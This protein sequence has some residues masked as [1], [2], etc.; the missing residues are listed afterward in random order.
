MA[1][2]SPGQRRADAQGPSHVFCCP[3]V[4]GVKR[5]RQQPPACPWIVTLVAIGGAD[6][7]KVIGNKSSRSFRSMEGLGAAA[8]LEG[9]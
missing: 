9:A 1:I 7:A 3:T 8:F 5:C 6:M 2:S 4:A